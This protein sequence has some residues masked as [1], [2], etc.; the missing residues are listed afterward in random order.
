M[1]DD[2]QL[3]DVKAITLMDKSCVEGG[4]TV[5]RFSQIKHIKSI[6]KTVKDIRVIGLIKKKYVV[7]KDV[8]FELLSKFHV[9]V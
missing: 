3:N 7:N 5:L 4:A 9:H 1:V 6:K 8:K 2:E